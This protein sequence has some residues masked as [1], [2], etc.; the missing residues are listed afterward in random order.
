MYDTISL[1]YI[2][3]LGTVYFNHS[4]GCQKCVVIGTYDTRMSF[5]ASNN[6][7]RT[8]YSFRN[9][10]DRLHHKTKSILEQ[11]PIDMVQDF[12]SSDPLH[13]IELGVMKRMLKI[14]LEKKTFYD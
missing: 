13:L 5:L 11:L 1:I 7:A 2:L 4:H 3:I 6:E 8:D 10:H 12:P 14:W 9:R